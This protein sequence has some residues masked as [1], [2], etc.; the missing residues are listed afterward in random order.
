MPMNYH[1]TGVLHSKNPKPKITPKLQFIVCRTHTISY[2]CVSLLKFHQKCQRGCHLQT[3][4]GSVPILKVQ[5][6]NIGNYKILTYSFR[7][8]KCHYVRTVHLF[9]IYSIVFKTNY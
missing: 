5:Y 6:I 2:L 8:Y 4:A 9:S 7:L 1:C 3:V